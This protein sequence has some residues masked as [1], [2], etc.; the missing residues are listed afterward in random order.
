MYAVIGLGNPGPQYEFTRHNIGARVVRCLAEQ[1]SALGSG[2][3]NW[4]SKFD[5]QFVKM[6]CGSKECLMVLPQSYMNLSGQAVK[7]LLKFYKVL[8]EQIL[9]VHDELDLA[10]GVIRVKK[11]GSAAGHRGVGDIIS[12]F[13]FNDFYRVRIGVGHP[14]CAG[15]QGE[16]A[17]EEKVHSAGNMGSKSGFRGDV[18]SWVLSE[19]GPE[20]QVLLEKAV[21]DGALA[22][23]QLL[24]EGLESVQRKFHKRSKI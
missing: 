4:Q 6:K 7:P 17:D 16:G 10:P 12:Q 15:L 9:V 22:V 20:E 19:P 23:R 24:E 11:G 8:S 13:G 3:V 5:C 1:S 21:S 2:S 14:S 18:S